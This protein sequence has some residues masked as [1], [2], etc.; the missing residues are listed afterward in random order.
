MKAL[1][2]PNKKVA[3]D[4]GALEML[5]KLFHKS[6][7]LTAYFITK[8][9]NLAEDVVQDT[10]LRAYDKLDQLQDHS[11]VETWLHRIASNLA[12]DVL[13]RN[14][15]LV[16]TP[17]AETDLK[18]VDPAAQPESSLLVKEERDNVV[19]AL[20]NLPP[21]YQE[22]IL[23]RY[24]REMTIKEISAFL[25]IPEGTVKTRLRKARILISQVL[26]HPRQGAAETGR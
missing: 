5:F 3:H 10:F 15:K 12:I 2:Y 24:Y 20:E 25:T 4:V 21:E 18:T 23:L 7:Y 19:S 1:R 14:K 6:V 17:P 9:H 22:V 11:K 8:D 16:S 26:N 13:R